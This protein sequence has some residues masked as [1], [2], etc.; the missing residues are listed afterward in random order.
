MF[1]MSALRTYLRYPALAM[2]CLLAACQTVSPLVAARSSDR[3]IELNVKVVRDRKIQAIVR[4]HQVADIARYRARLTVWDDADGRFVDL[5]TPIY[6]NLGPDGDGTVTFNHL[7]PYRYQVSVVGE[8]AD[9]E[10][11]TTAQTAEYDLTNPA[12]DFSAPLARTVQMAMQPVIYAGTLALPTWGAGGTLPAGAESVEIEIRDPDGGVVAQHAY[13]PGQ[14]FRA[15]NLQAGVTYTLSGTATFSGGATLTDEATFTADADAASLDTDIPLPAGFSLYP[16]DYPAN[17]GANRIAADSQ[18]GVWVNDSG[19]TLDHLTVSANGVPTRASQ[20]VPHVISSEGAGGAMSAMA[21]DGAGGVWVVKA[22][23]MMHVTPTQA[24]YVATTVGADYGLIVPDGSGGV[25][26]SARHNWDPKVL[27]VTESAGTTTM[28]TVG[29]DGTSPGAAVTDDAG[30]VWVTTSNRVVRHVTPAL[31]SGA[32]APSIPLP[33]GARPLGALVADGEGGAYVARLDG[34]QVAHVL[35]D[36]TTAVVSNFSGPAT[37]LAGDH[38]GGFWWASGTKLG[39]TPGSGAELT[40]DLTET[41]LAIQGATDGTT[42][43]ALMA[44]GSLRK[45]TRSGTA[46][47]LSATKTVAADAVTFT[48]DKNQR[49]SVVAPGRVD[50]ILE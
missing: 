13:G 2:A 19:G 23:A 45:Y 44:G 20:I 36:N 48:L 3:A 4:R 5:P 30:G 28:T 26:V 37:R 11:I 14:A 47:S 50:V 41:P 21:A 10:A 35:P 22:P 8:N 39:H 1:R 7:G 32:T 49:P 9:G 29:L 25:W 18:G 42:L 33:L 6:K 46:I 27:H 16:T 40:F 38:G 24:T 15:T 34:T 31:A 17:G 43:W 12:G